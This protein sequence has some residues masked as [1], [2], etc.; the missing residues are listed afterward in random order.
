ME[1]SELFENAI[2]WLKDN[3]GQFQFFVER[4]L[5]WTVQTYL[6]SQIKEYGLPYRVFNDYPILPG[7]RRSLCADLAI[8]N[9]DSLVEVAAEFKYEPSHT[10]GDICVLAT[11]D[12]RSRKRPFGLSSPATFSLSG[13]TQ[14]SI[15]EGNRFRSPEK[16]LV[17]G[18]KPSGK[19]C[20]GFRRGLPKTSSDTMLQ[21]GWTWS[22]SWTLAHLLLLQAAQR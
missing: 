6:F 16:T 15:Q 5:V 7:N 13:K 20:K 4:D 22:P 10:R 3:Y 8:L 19:A 2:A 21:A 11:S 14:P 17:L 12:I 1:A 18:Q 9:T